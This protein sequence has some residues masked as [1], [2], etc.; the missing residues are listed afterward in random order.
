MTAQPAAIEVK[1][2]GRS[3]G[4]TRALHDVS[5]TVPQGAICGLLGSNGAGKTTAMAIITG[6]DRPGSGEV[7]IEGKTPFESDAVSEIISFVRDNQRYP[8]DFRLH[9]ILRVAPLFHRDWDSQF[10]ERLAALFGLPKRTLVKK[11]S[12]GQ[13]S[14]LA[15]VIGLASRAPITVFDEPYLGLDIVAR[16]RFYEELLA[17]QA[18]HPRTFLISTHLVEEMEQIFDRVV[19]LNDGKVVLDAS[20]EDLHGQATEVTGKYA[21]LTEFTAQLPV[22]RLRKVGSLASAIIRPGLTSAQMEEAQQRG[23][24][25]A[26]VALHDLIAAFGNTYSPDADSEA[27]S[28]GSQE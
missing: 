3:F 28:R 19:V 6:Q 21:E 7:V 17:D 15:I 11:Y 5:F 14:A 12:R 25:T 2:L 22:L 23:L 4:T 20:A 10:A 27:N 13:L 1:N 24:S 9:H 18:A 8:D 26:P 16:E